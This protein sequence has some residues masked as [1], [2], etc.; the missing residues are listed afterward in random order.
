MKTLE[1]KITQFYGGVSDDIRQSS[2]TAFA[3]SKHFDIFSHPNR[4]TP[5]RSFEADANDGSTSDGMKQYAV[6]DFLYA[7]TTARLWGLGQKT[8]KTKIFYK[9]DATQGNW[10][11]PSS[12]EGNGAIQNGCLTE[13]KDYLWGFQGT[14]QVFKF[15]TLSGSP[16]ITD[17]AGTT[18]STITSVAQGIIGKDDN[19]YLPYNNVLMR[20][21]SGGT[22]NDNVLVLPTDLKIVSLTRY[23]NYL[24][25]GCAPILSFNGKSVVFLWNYTSSDVQETIDWG[26]GDLRILEN[27][28]GMLVGI[29][30]RYLNNSTG[31]GRGS[32]IIQVYSQGSPGVLKEV[33][34]QKLT[35]KT[36]PLS[37]A[38]K[39]NR[40]FFAAKIFTNAAGTEYDEGIW[41]FGRKNANYPWALTLD[42][43]DENI[44]TSGIQSIGVAGNFFFIAHSA[45]GSIDKTDDAVTY[46]F[47]SIYE[48]QTFNYGDVRTLKKLMK[49]SL[50]TVPLPT[51]SSVTVKYKVNSDSAWT[52]IG[53]FN[54]LNGVYRDFI[55]IE[56]TDIAFATG[57]EFKF[58][59]E[60]LGGAEITGFL[61]ET[62]ELIG[63]T[64]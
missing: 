33:F 59:L 44:N 64:D 13:Y 46:A 63:S 58:R 10:S 16:S 48:S 3:I 52:T 31:A 50:F 28:E 1:T 8:A 53:T 54:T 6:Q 38:V 32:L 42:L 41:S 18:A 45:D 60:S 22:V 23:G 21:T 43:I 61:M 26:E 17:S 30:D 24:A 47:T 27:I 29:T 20:V 34:T 39:N 14:N 19:L 40:L 4:L 15:G 7:H 5:Y 57:H 55:A 56:A 11:L 49:F 62:A 12:A 35:G 2:A 51:S 36:I 9:A 25:V 37:K